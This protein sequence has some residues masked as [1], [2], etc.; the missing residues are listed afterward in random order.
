[1]ERKRLI[2]KVCP[3]G[4]CEETAVHYAAKRRQKETD[5]ISMHLS[6]LSVPR[7]RLQTNCFCCCCCS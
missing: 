5:I 1:M 2:H 7:A 4:C 6:P 3:L